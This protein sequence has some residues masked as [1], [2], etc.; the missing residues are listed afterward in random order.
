MGSSEKPWYEDKKKPLYEKLR[1][2]RPVSNQSSRQI[3]HK[4]KPSMNRRKSFHASSSSL[5]FDLWL[6]RKAMEVHQSQK[7]KPTMSPEIKKE[8][9]DISFK[10]W[11]HKKLAHQKKESYNQHTQNFDEVKKDPAEIARAFTKW[12]DQ[13]AK[14]Q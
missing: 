1:E 6:K 12:L 3:N 4:P 8:Q 14:L 11:L 2:I 7:P 9:A 13:K 10:K 5:T